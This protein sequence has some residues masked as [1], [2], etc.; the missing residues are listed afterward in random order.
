MWRSFYSDITS[1]ASAVLLQRG[2]SRLRPILLSMFR[3]CVAFSYIPNAWRKVKV[4]FISKP[5]GQDYTL[6][7]SY[8]P[9]SLTS[10]LLKTLK[11]LR[12]S[13]DTALHTN[14]IA[15]AMKD[16]L[17]TLGMFLDTEGSFDKTT[18]KS[19]ELALQEHDVNPTLSRWVTGML[20]NREV[21]INVSGTE[22]EAVVDRRCSQ[23]GVISSV[24]W[25][26]IVHN[27][28]RPTP[29]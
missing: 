15:W 20:T 16:K 2:I 18:L 3:A 24:L 13:T 11:R 6:V 5:V 22:I 14:R 10:F 29:Q 19:I 27:L 21:L 1:T 4:I 12:R 26:T 7:K 17:S 9:I 25:D 28:I 23:G 8:R